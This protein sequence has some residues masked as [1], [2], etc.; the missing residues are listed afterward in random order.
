[1][2]GLFTLYKLKTKHSNG[3]HYHVS[4]LTVC[5]DNIGHF[6]SVMLKNYESRA[7]V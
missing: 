3:A 6:Q 4:L 1:M 5:I 2:Y 7:Y